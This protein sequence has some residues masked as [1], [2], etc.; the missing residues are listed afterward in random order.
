MLRLCSKA[1]LISGVPRFV[2]YIS[3]IAK[4]TGVELEVA[5]EWEKK[6]RL[7]SEVVICGSKFID[8]INAVD[9]GKIRLVLKTNE[10]VAPFVEKGIS[11]FIFD[12]NNV[13]E[14]AFSFFVPCDDK[15]NKD[16]ELSDIMSITE[17]KRFTEGE[18]DFNFATN[19]FK[20]CG[21]GIY[22][23][24]SEKAYLAKWLFLN[25]KDNNKRIILFNLRKRFG[26]A[27]MQDIDRL[28]KY[29]G[30]KNG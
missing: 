18:Y 17:R 9:Y 25:K 14:V 6:Y 16:I 30:G 4:D 7:D 11:H 19:S 2:K 21:V 22:L 29:T 5:D 24:E 15:D 20:Y 10:T 28:G 13:K 12:Y 26:K 8:C 27:F 3:D 1:L 23:K